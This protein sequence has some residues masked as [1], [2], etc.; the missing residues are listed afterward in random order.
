VPST[1]NFSTITGQSVRAAAVPLVG[2][3]SSY[4]LRSLGKVSP[5]ENQGTSPA[6][7]AF[8]TYGSLESYLLPTQWSF[9]ENNMKNLAGFDLTCADGG[10]Q[11]MATAY[12][13]RWG[14][15]MQSGPVTTACDPF[16][17]GSCTDSSSCSVQQHVQNVLYLPYRASS[18]DNNNIKWALQNY[19]GVYAT[20][21]F[22]PST[23]S[24]YN[25]NTAA[26]YYSGSTAPDHAVTIVGWNDSYA[27]SN[28][29]SRP[30]GP[31]AFIVKNSWGTSFGKSGFFYVS[32]YDNQFATNSQPPTVFTAQPTTN[33]NANYQ[34]DPLGWVTSVGSPNMGSPASNTA[35]GANVFTATSNQQLSAV[36]FYAG[37]VNTQYHVYVY[38]G[39][40]SGPIGG[41]AYTGPNGTI[42]MPG[43]YTIPLN[44]TVPITAGHKFSVVIE[45]TTPGSNYPIPVENTQAGYSSSA[46][47]QPGQSYLSATGGSWTDTYT[48]DSTMNICIKAFAKTAPVG[49]APAVTAQNANSLD[50]FVNGTD[51]ALYHKYWTGTTWTP[52]T[53][54]G[55]NST[56]DPAATSRAP[57]SIDV[58]T[59][60]T[61]GALW[62]TNTTNNGTSWS[63]WYK[64]GGQLA[65]GTGPAADARGTNSLDVFVQGT[66][67][68]LYYTH[69]DGTAWSAWHSLGGVLTS[70]PAAT[71]SGNGVIDVFVRGTDGAIW[72]R[73][74]TNGG[75]TWSNWASL[76]GQLASGTGPAA[77]LQGSRLD[78]FAE[79]T[80][81]ALY[82]KT[83]TGSWSGWI[84]LGGA[85]TSSPAATSPTSGVID[86]FVRGTDYALWEK[87]YRG[88]W[89]GW[90]SV[91]GL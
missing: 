72:E 90:I 62:S 87:T 15:S 83:S 79:G 85:L 77:C 60:S 20:M 82:Q 58:F 1:V 9:S 73:T 65:P 19:G 6:C 56:A 27:A 75:A 89:S 49:G 2:Y 18:T 55:G 61:D 22:D 88:V 69:W 91:G 33:Y 35:W 36:S 37:S 17:Q 30:P 54:L 25:S 26:Y 68:V 14:G 67:H 78:V 32:Y 46:T 74:T 59:R 63:N 70:S 8:A 52:S 31:G 80:N 16:N 51:G 40:T 47:A 64:I 43:Y 81:G 29:A 21:W 44:T 12:L 10:N 57:G 23:S 42:A 45:I 28:F 66:D 34:Y 86:V 3:P 48:L 71:S 76:G 5:V 38:T 24:N 13:A 11:Q 7:W 4:D 50:L 41:T 53:S 84:S 39:P